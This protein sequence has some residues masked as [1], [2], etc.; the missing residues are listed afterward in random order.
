[1]AT[2]ANSAPAQSLA[3]WLGSVKI[4]TSID[5]GV[6]WIN[7]GAARGITFTENAEITDIQADNTPDLDSNVS[8]HTVDVSF[9]ALEFYLPTLNDL[10]GGIDTLTTVVGAATTA[11]D[12][13]STG[14]VDYGQILMLSNQ[15]ASDTVAA[16]SKVTAVTT[17]NSC[18]TLDS[19]SD[20]SIITDASNHQGIILLS[21]ASGGSFNDTEGIFI[22]Y[23]YGAIASYK[24]SSGGKSSILPRWFRLTNKEIVTGVTK[25]RIITLYSVTLSKGL[26]LAFKSSNESDAILENGMAF[27]AKLDATRTEGDQLFLI[28]DQKATA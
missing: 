15:G 23:A 19:T 4:E 24:M 28:E 26:E 14:S 1:M 18:T 12:T 11:T 27:K 25:Y 7:V 21:T 6:N 2:F 20:Y 16:V 5:D 13:Y 22:K 17:G 10:R 8:A 3:P 9:S